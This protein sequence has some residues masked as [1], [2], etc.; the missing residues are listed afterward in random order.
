VNNECF[1][2]FRADDLVPPEY[3]ND[4]ETTKHADLG[5]AVRWL[6]PAYVSLGYRTP[7][8]MAL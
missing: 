3:A 6:F 4:L 2:V 1:W 5:Y 7:I 8:T